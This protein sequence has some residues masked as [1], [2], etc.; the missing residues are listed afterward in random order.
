M[1]GNDTAREFIQGLNGEQPQL[2]RAVEMLRVLS[3]ERRPIAAITMSIGGND[4][5]EVGERCASQPCTGLFLEILE[6]M[7]ADLERIYP[8]L[9]A[10]KPPDT[11]LMVVTYYNASD[12]GQPGVDT[13][14]TELGQ[15]VWNATI[16]DV[17]GRNG[18]FIVDGY[19]PFKG[20]ACDL[21]DGVDPNYAGY[22]VLAEAYERAYEALPSQYISPFVRVTQ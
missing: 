14:P 1:A 10:A 16:S 9:V 18:A 7:K 20:R 21:I 3:D 2:D 19:T 22:E 11:P 15:R 4:Y 5:V 17:A 13:S 12:C 8:D 6:R